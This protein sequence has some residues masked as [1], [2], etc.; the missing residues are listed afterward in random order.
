MKKIMIVCLFSLIANLNAHPVD[1][2]KGIFEDKFRQLDEIFPDPNQYR[3]AT[4]EPTN[5]YWQQQADYKIDIELFEDERSLKGSET[6]K[7]TNN[8]PL[9]LKYIWIQLDQNIFKQDSID[10]QTRTISSNDKINFSTLRNTNF[11]DDFIGGIQNLS[12]KVNGSKV[13]TKIVG[14]MVR[15]DLNQKLKMDE[16]ILIKIDWDFNIGETN[17][18]DSR[19]GYE[20]FEDGNDIFLIA[21]WYPR[22]VAFSDYEGWH[23]KEFIGNGEFTLEFGNYDVSIK[24]P[25]DHIVSSTGVLINSERILSKEH[26]KRLKQAEKSETPIFIVSPEEALEIEKER[27]KDKKTWQFKAENVRDF[28]WASSRK[29]IWDAAGYKQDS[30]ENPLVMAMSFYP[31]EGEP[32]W[33]KYSTEVVMHTLKIYSKYTFDYPYPTAQS[34]NGPVGGMEYPMITFN[35]PRTVAD[36]NGT[37]TYSRSEKEFLIG[38]IIHEIGHIYFPMIVN[39]DERQWTWMDEGLNTFLQFIAEQEWDIDYR[40]DRGEARWITN[41]MLSNNQ[42]PIM[43]NSESLLQ[44]GNNAYG[45]PATALN[46]LRET[47]LGRELFDFA[48]KEYANRWKFKRPTPYD[49]FRTMEEA[50]GVDLDWFW[51]GWFFSTNHV[52]ISIEKISKGTLD[53]LDPKIDSE[54]DRIDR[55]LEPEALADIRNTEEGIIT[56]VIERPDL[57]DIYDEYDEFTPGIEQLENYE[58]ILEDLKDETN[59]DPYWKKNALQ[60]ALSKNQNYYIIEFKNNGGLMMPIPLEINYKNGEKEYIKI[61]AEIWRK[62]QKNVKWLKRTEQEIQSVIMDPYWEI[63]DTD[64]ENN[65]YP[66]RMVPTRLKPIARKSSKKNLMRDLMKRNQEIASHSNVNNE[67]VSDE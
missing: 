66:R 57:L 15:V 56:K 42:V 37:R 34:V 38:V 50:S 29:F 6:I 27:S 47:V 33:S 28:A 45:K 14:T 19:N 65:Y 3:A 13:N 52:D 53:T 9:D 1:Q 60:R 41:Y 20:T 48:F 26:R 11:M 18:L 55:S 51:Q 12:I 59:S 61:P 64:L 21:Q 17:A 58:E 67:G 10:F 39:S 25:A 54:K 23:N 7:Y 30:E 35:G 43:T 2:S 22:L 36:E 4:G 8:S 44:F 24:V 32:L 31:N 16:S 62:K 46:I 63:A 40:S 49:F 5:K